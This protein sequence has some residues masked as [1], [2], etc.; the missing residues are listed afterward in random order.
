MSC[1]TEYSK[2]T[3]SSPARGKASMRTVDKARGEVAGTECGAS[4]VGRCV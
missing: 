2:D 1:V 4:E 3:L